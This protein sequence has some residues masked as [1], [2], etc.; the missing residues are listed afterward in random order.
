MKIFN[1]HIIRHSE[2]E[3]IK[4]RERLLKI[5]FTDRQIEQILAGVN[6]LWCWRR[7]NCR[8]ILCCSGNCMVIRLGMIMCGRIG[9]LG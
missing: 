1:W 3:K 6:S 8:F 5:R 9:C 7:R 2:M 4:A